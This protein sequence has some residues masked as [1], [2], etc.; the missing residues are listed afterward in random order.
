MS[1]GH[2]LLQSIIAQLARLPAF[3]TE[4]SPLHGNTGP[5]ESSPASPAAK[6]PEADYSQRET[7]DRER[8]MRIMTATWM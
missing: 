8:E 2:G 7:D 3:G 1:S 6:S 4:R 5:V